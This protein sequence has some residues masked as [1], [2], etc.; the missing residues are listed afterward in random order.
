MLKVNIEDE[1]KR[2]RQNSKDEAGETV[3][4][5][6]LLLEGD[7]SKE[8]DLLKKIGLGH[9]IKEAEKVNNI[10]L[11]RSTFETEYGNAIIMCRSEIKD[12]ALKYDLKFL[13]ANHFKG[14]VDLNIGPKVRRFVDDNNIS[15]SKDD[16]FLLG[17]GK[18]FNL[19]KKEIV[20]RQKFSVDLDPI[21]FYKVPNNTIEDMYV[22]VHKWGNDFTILRYLRGLVLENFKSY[23]T[24]QLIM[25]F[26]GALM[27]TNYLSS[28]HVISTGSVILSVVL[29]CVYTLIITLVRCRDLSKGDD[30]DR[31]FNTYN[32]HTVHKR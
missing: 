28:N 1:V 25:G 16:F 29:A 10:D 31:A 19:Q 21:L 11:E 24:F 13:G 32:W 30:Y 14:A 12:L 6:Q 17:P 15:P 7:E 9:Q 2:K 18:A 5:A 3:K 20:G 27:T 22:M 23:L 4:S 26:T 8:R